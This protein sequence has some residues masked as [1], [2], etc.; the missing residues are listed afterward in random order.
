[1]FV[2]GRFCKDPKLAKADDFFF[3]GLNKPGNTDNKDGSNVTAVYVDKIPGLNTLGLQLV[4]I[5]Y[6]PYGQNPPHSHPRASE[7]FVVLEGQLLAGFVTSN[8]ADGSNRL[9]AKVLNPGDVF[10]FPLGLIH[11]QLNLGH[12]PALA[13][14][15]FGGQNAGRI[16]IAN[17]IF[18]ATPPINA[19]I[20]S[21]AFKLDK[22]IVEFLQKQPWPDNN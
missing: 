1:M 10:I 15:A 18:G 13:F 21:R 7:I 16:T 8:Q 22:N 3:S 19:D 20:L 2:N 12:T 4:R 11:F 17:A 9:F 6:A 14:A 5:D